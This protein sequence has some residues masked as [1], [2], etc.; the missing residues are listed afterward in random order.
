MPFAI[1]RQISTMITSPSALREQRKQLARRTQITIDR[2]KGA[3]FSSKYSEHQQVQF[4][5]H[6]GR[7]MRMKMRDG[8]GLINYVNFG[9]SFIRILF[10]LPSIRANVDN[11]LILRLQ[12]TKRC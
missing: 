1:V 7:R 9:N 10:S 5:E 4:R 8:N 11:R 2:P 6:L 12:I 3:K